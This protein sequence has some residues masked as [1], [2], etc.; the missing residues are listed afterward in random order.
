VLNAPLTLFHCSVRA[1]PAAIVAH[2]FGAATGH[3]GP[4]ASTG[5]AAGGL[6]NTLL[7]PFN[8]IGSRLATPVQSLGTANMT[9]R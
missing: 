7:E 2:R 6:C 3:R 5:R 1:H 9:G 8:L 4:F